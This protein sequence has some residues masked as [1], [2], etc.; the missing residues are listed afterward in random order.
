MGRLQHSDSVILMGFRASDKKLTLL[1]SNPLPVKIEPR[2]RHCLRD[3]RRLSH[4]TL[5]V[6]GRKKLLEVWLGRML[7]CGFLG[8]V[9]SEY[10]N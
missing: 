9:P 1:V 10:D 7:V 4:E 8:L 6:H 2:L 5:F 3:V